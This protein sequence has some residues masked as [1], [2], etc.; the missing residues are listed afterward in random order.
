MLQGQG[1]YPV[2]RRP[3]LAIPANACDCHF[4]IVGPQD[5]Y[6]FPPGKDYVPTEALT[7]DYDTH[8]APIGIERRVI[9]ATSAYGLDNRRIEAALAT[10]GK[11]RTRAVATLG[12][13]VTAAEIARLHDLGFRA[14]RI[15]EW[16]E[17]GNSLADLETLAAKVAPF[18]W[19]IELCMSVEHLADLKAR[20]RTLPADVVFDHMGFLPVAVPL[21][22]PGRRSLIELLGE[23]RSWVK[24]SSQ[25]RLTAEG[26]P[27]YA[28]VAPM[29]R[30]LV[31]ANP[32]RVV[33]GTDWPHPM[34]NGPLPNAGDL[35]DS[36]AD[37]TEDPAQQRRILVENPAALYDF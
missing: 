6:P 26:P 14:V 25:Y 27:G 1:P 20:I 11:H 18:D 5:A 12:A 32:E 19:H 23:G 21:D 31:A 30:A 24:L 2:A 4:H 13:A 34:F 7:D 16:I 37:W 15:F 10:W 28:D 33:W 29:A 35:I 8:V 3:R 36:I 17:G 22:H 9:V